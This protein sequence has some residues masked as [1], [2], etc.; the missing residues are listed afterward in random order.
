MC[1]ELKNLFA[2]ECQGKKFKHNCLPQGWASFASAFHFRMCNILAHTKVVVYVDDLLVAG[3]NQ[4]E[5][6]H[7]LGK[8][9]AKLHEASMHVNK[10]KM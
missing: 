7:N 1:E 4:E 9:L 10:E 8:V 3:N 2:F 6:D 5:Y